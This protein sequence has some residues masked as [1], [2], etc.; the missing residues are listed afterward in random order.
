MVL[1][2]SSSTVVSA[3][4]RPCLVFFYTT[5]NEVCHLGLG[6][7]PSF[8]PNAYVSSGLFVSII[9]PLVSIVQ[10]G[11]SLAA[12]ILERKGADLDEL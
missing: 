2:H 12:S 3:R 4:N 9:Y 11:D 10:A 6:F 8:F 7:L 5:F 1:S